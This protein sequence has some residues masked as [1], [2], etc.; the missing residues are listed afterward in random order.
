MMDLES[1]GRSAALSRPG[2]R[3]PRRTTMLGQIGGRS[4]DGSRL[5]WRRHGRV[6][7]R[8]CAAGA[9]PPSA[10][11]VPPLHSGDF[12][13]SAMEYADGRAHRFEQSVAVQQARWSRLAVVAGLIIALVG[14]VAVALTQVL[15]SNPKTAIVL[16]ILLVVLLGGGGW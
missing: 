16:G 4:C 12:S 5:Q 11:T 14:N 6:P 8:D 9:T 13:T 7:N 15:P 3:T 2:R 1:G 10:A